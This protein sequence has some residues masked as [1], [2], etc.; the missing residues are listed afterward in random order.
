MI[1]VVGEPGVID[2]FDSLVVAQEFGDT[3]RILDVL[4]DPQG[5]RFLIP[6]NSRKALSGDKTEPVVR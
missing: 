6:C 2:P 1:W 3:T 4:L 5:D